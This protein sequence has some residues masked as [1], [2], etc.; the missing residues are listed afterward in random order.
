MAIGSSLTGVFDNFIL[1]SCIYGKYY[2]YRISSVHE[3]RHLLITILLLIF[4]FVILILLVS[5]IA[6]RM[7][8]YAP[9]RVKDTDYSMPVGKQYDK[10]RPGIAKS[11]DEMLARS[12]EPV[13]ITSYDGKKLFA[14]YYHA[15]DGAPLQIQ[16]H[17]Y[18]SSA[19]LDFCGGSKLAGRLGHNALVVDQRS[20]GKSEGKAITFGIKERKD[21]L[22]WIEYARSRFGENVKIILAGLSMGAATVLMATDLK[23]PDNVIGVMADCPYSSPKE[24]IM[25]VCQDMHLPPK[26]LYP[27]IKLGARLFAHFNLEESSAVNAVKQTKLPILL[28]HGEADHFVPCSMSRR[29]YEVCPSRIMLETIPDAGHGLSYMVNPQKY[30]DVTVEFIRKISI[31]KI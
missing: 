7:A 9:T 14:R 12:Y 26:L 5:Y 24:I 28:I 10:V 6:Y 22:S 3:V 29:I 11:V 17:G 19:V 27:F 2:S 25:K 16:F 30:E 13:T 8:F 23:L 21:C 15:A 18:K 1:I 31:E 20:H 4:I